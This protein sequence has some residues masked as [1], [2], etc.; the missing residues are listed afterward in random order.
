MMLYDYQCSNF[1][2]PFHRLPD[3]DNSICDIIPNIAQALNMHKTKLNGTLA[4]MCVRSSVP[5]ISD[6]IEKEVIRESCLASIRSPCYARINVLK[7]SQEYVLKELQKNGFH[8]VEYLSSL[9]NHMKT[10]CVVDAN[11]LAF[12]SD[13]R[14][15]LDLE[16][17]TRMGYLALQV[18]IQ[19]KCVMRCN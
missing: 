1:T 17:M 14:K 19:A 18:S 11:F 10:F 9:R 3:P 4:R 7:C 16:P 6:L 12:S 15:I 5:I 13:C 2:I 8:S